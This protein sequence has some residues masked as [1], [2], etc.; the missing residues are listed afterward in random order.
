M[1]FQGV[2]TISPGKDDRRIFKDMVKL[3]PDSLQED[4]DSLDGDKVRVLEICSGGFFD[5][6]SLPTLNR[7]L[8]ALEELQIEDV[9]MSEITLNAELTPK[10]KVIKFKNVSDVVDCKFNI[11][12]PTL[13]TFHIFYYGPGDFCWILR[14]LEN[15]PALA[16]FDSYKLR[17][18][19]LGFYSNRLKSIRL[20]RAELL[21]RIDLWTPVLENLNVQAAYDLERFISSKIMHSRHSCLPTLCAVMNFM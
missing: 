2:H 10:L 18:E 16:E 5:N 8:P 17:V 4:I 20:R 3:T 15:A 12:L 19:Y 7:K 9:N 13:E 11:I 1:V 21:T 14:M 6:E